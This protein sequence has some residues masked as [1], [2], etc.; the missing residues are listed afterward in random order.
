MSLSRFRIFALLAVLA[1]LATVFAAC[2]GSDRNSEDPQQVLD[3]AT[4][5]G[6]ESGNARYLAWRSNPKARKAATSTSPSPA[7]S[8]A[9]APRTLPELALTASANGR[10]PKAKTSISRAA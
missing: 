2:G 1:T 10:R 8:R 5:E 7:R 6:V 4:L 9:A 3:S